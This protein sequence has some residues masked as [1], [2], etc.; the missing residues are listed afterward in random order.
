MNVRQMSFIFG[1]FLRINIKIECPKQE[2]IF[3]DLRMSEY[4]KQAGF[5]AEKRSDRTASS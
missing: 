2:K 3:E 1:F 5:I 4:V